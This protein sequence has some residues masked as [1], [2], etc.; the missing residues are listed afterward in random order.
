LPM[1]DR[2]EDHPRPKRPDVK[3]RKPKK[4]QKGLAPSLIDT[5]LFRAVII[6]VF[7]GALVM[8]FWFYTH[9]TEVPLP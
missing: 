9:P 7:V 4:H 1:L 2:E 5:I 8:A 6:L 3:P